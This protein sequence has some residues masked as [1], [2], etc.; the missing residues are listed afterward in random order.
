MT[1]YKQL[2]RLRI[3]KLGILLYDA[4]LTAVKDITE[5]AE[6]M[7]ISVEEYQAY[8]S[9]MQSPSLPEIESL[10]YFLKVPLEHF[11]GSESRSQAESAD[12]PQVENERRQERDR[13]IGERLSQ[14]L[15]SSRLTLEKLSARTGLEEETITAYHKGERSIP[16]PELET[17]A[18][19][20]NISMEEFADDSGVIG[21]WR[22]QQ[23]AIKQFVELPPD[24]QDFISR[25]VNRSFLNMA[26]RFSEMPADKL[27]MIAESLLEITY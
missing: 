11:W 12:P 26:V 6:A 16:L 14:G 21:A 3:R 8:E 27:R 20:L 1:D 17:L 19:A 23:R 18:E 15:E 5:C 7:G 10:A 22:V 24:M 25:P 9:G 2:I 4:R 13:I